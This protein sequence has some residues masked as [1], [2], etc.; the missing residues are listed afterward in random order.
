MLDK[1]AHSEEINFCEAYMDYQKAISERHA[2]RSYLDKPIAADVKAQLQAVVD[3]CN[4]K[5]GLHFQ[6]VFDEPEAFDSMMA[7]Y[8]KFSGVKNYVAIVCKRGD[9][10]KAGYYG[11]HIALTA[12]ALGLN[13]CWVAMSYKKVK[14]AFKVASGEKLHVVIALGYGATAGVQHR[15]KPIE[16]V[17][18]GQNPPQWFVDGVK[19][20][21]LAPTAMNQQ[22]FT[23][24]YADGKVGAKAGMG[25]YVKTDLGIAKYHFE[26]GSGKTDLNWI[27]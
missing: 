8:G 20:A 4:A 12:Q 14:T 5:G 2:V 1:I 15:S 16:Q 7:H 17:M 10:E 27:K 11:E 22:K 21:L 13:T 25:F 19:C 6:L 26:I 23:F 24:T 3:E 18:E 9:E